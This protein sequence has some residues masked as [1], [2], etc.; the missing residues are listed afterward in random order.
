MPLEPP[1]PT[2]D[3][4]ALR[5][6]YDA[7]PY[8]SQALIETHPDRIASVATLFGLSPPTV[9]TARVLELGCARGGNLIP[10][11][12]ELPEARFLGIDLSPRQIADG[13]SSIETLGLRNIEL[14]A[15]SLTELGDD[16]GPFDYILCHGVY[17][18]VPEPVRQAILEIC[19]R[20]LV[21]NGVAY[22]SYNTFPG[23]LIPSLIRE[24][25][26]GHV[27]S[28]SDPVER[29]RR[30]RQLVETLARSI[31]DA[32]S[33]Y[34]LLVQKEAAEIQNKSDTYLLHEHLDSVN[35]PVYV[36]QFLEQTTATGLRYLGDA[37]IGSM[38]ALQQPRIREIL[39]GL[40]HDPSEQEQLFDALHNRRFRRSLLVRAD[41]PDPPRSTP[42]TDAMAGLRISTL[43]A[44]AFASPDLRAGVAASFRPFGSTVPFST[45]DPMTKALLVVLSE[46]HPRSLPFE[47]LWT[48]VRSRLARALGGEGPSRE[49]VAAAVL[50]GLAASIVDMHTLEFRFAAE[51]GDRPTASP[52]ARLQAESQGNVVNL[53]HRLVLL[54]EFDRLVIRQLDGRRDFEAVLGAVEAAILAGQFTIHQD[55]QPITDPSQI[56]PILRRSIP[57][58]LQR[59]ASFALLTS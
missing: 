8:E 34:A 42:S 59:L 15:M 1:S 29:V 22:V 52:I 56:R 9:A 33:P 18:W 46:S 38:P 47:T 14:R 17:S 26:L 25:M 28:V 5:A 50:S 30:A 31:P 54:S 21:P 37:R 2:E 24:M 3:E 7:V 23:W 39:E 11:A 35:E 27:R 4:Q 19:A 53:R 16:L 6:S 51:P 10:M 40:S 48:L 12:L 55:N 36:R 32:Q 13:Q 49:Q 20:R 44:P 43:V 45:T 58:S 57:P 41:A